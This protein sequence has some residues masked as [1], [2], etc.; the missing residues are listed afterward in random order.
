ME[1]VGV[2]LVLYSLCKYWAT[3]DYLLSICFDFVFWAVGHGVGFLSHFWWWWWVSGTSLLT[4]WICSQNLVPLWGL[5]TGRCYLSIFLLEDS[6]N[7]CKQ[8][9]YFQFYFFH[10]FSLNNIGCFLALLLK[11]IA[12]FIND[13]CS[14]FDWLTVVCLYYFS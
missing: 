12:L 3:S 10:W 13:W 2:G 11:N 4:N 5:P 9:V 6:R 8:S 14:R 1:V 7:R